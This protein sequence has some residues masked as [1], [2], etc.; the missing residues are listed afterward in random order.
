MELE[1]A[2]FYL[3]KYIT[4]LNYTIL[5]IFPPIIIARSFS[6][7]EINYPNLTIGVSSFIVALVFLYFKFT[8]A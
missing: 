8:G 4:A 2:T 7:K 5:L 3:L 1:Q 6:K